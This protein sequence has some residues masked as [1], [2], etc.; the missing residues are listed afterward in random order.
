VNKDLFDS[1][2][3]AVKDRDRWEKKQELFYRMRNGGVRRKSMPYPGAPDLSY[4][5]GDTLIEKLKPA[6]IQQMYGSET[7]ASFVSRRTQDEDITA[8]ASYWYD[9]QLKQRSNFERTRR[10][11]GLACSCSASIG[12]RVPR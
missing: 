11:R 2:N 1:I 4:P 9:Y 5:L 3:Q 7:I 10:R 6:Y 12:S 8:A